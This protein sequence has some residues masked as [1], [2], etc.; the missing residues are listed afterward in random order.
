MTRPRFLADHDFNEHILHGVERQE[1]T[2]ED[3]RT[4]F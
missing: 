1:P 2:I 3:Y 4:L